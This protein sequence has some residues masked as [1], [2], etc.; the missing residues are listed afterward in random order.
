ETCCVLIHRLSPGRG[1][2]S[3]PSPKEFLWPSKPR[4]ATVERSDPGRE[5]H[6]RRDRAHRVP[7]RGRRPCPGLLAGALRLAVPGL[8]DARDGL[9][10]GPGGGGRGS[11]LPVRPARTPEL[12]LR[13]RRHRRVDREGAAARRPGGRP[14]AGA[15]PRLV[16][17]LLGQRGE[18]V[19]PL[20]GGRVGWMIDSAPPRGGRELEHLHDPA[21][22]G[23]GL[24]LTRRYATR[25]P[26]PTS[27]GTTPAT[28][29]VARD[30]TAVTST[31]PSSIA[32]SSAELRRPL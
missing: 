28:S 21:S 23:A 30:P 16:R 13:D 4:G 8:R 12:L 14:R 9:P 17:P 20:A 31:P 11:G 1:S 19:P 18:R 25:H 15:R 5:R 10:D 27:A 22:T 7:G 32:T 24:A 2:A 29:S 6:V 26:A 3:T